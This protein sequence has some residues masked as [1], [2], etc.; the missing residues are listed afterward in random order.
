MCGIAGI[1][2]CAPIETRRS[3]VL[4]MMDLLAHR[5]TG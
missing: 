3:K 2:A 1:I 4:H 5:G